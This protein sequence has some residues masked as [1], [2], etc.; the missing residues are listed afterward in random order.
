MFWPVSL[1]TLSRVPGG[2]GTAGAEMLGH[3]VCLQSAP[4]PSDSGPYPVWRSLCAWVK[5]EGRG[6]PSSVAVGGR[7]VFYQME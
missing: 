5:I 7:Q 3:G 2:S 1:E 6:C 4:T